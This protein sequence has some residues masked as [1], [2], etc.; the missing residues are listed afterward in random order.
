MSRTADSLAAWILL[1]LALYA[2]GLGVGLLVERLSGFRLPNALLPAVGAL[3][4][5]VLVMIPYRLGLSAVVATPLLVVAAG[6]GVWLARRELRAR[7]NPGAAGFAALGIYLLYMAP[8]ILSG[9]WTWTGYNF[10]N[11]TAVQMLLADHL[12]LDGL[13]KPPGSTTTELSIRTY[14]D[15]AYPTGSHALLGTLAPL[16]PGPLAALYQPYIAALAGLTAMALTRLASRAGLTALFAGLAAFAAVAANLTYNYGLHGSVKEIAMLCSL[17]VSVAVAREMLGSPQ[18]VRGAAVF[19]VTMGAG[20]LIFSSAALP[21]VA[22]LGLLV[23][24]LAVLPRE[25]PLRSPRRLGI[26]LGLAVPVLLIASLPALTSIFRFTDVASDAFADEGARMY[27]LAHLLR[28]L[29][30]LQS[31][32]VWL[33]NDYRVPSETHEVLTDVLLWVMMGAAVIGVVALVRR[34][35]PGVLLFSGTALGVYLIMQPRLSPYTDAKL[36]AVLSP[37]IV[38]TAAVGLALIARIRWWTA[39]PAGLCAAALLG[40]I[41]W[42]DAE[43]YH[44]TQI[45]PVEKMLAMEDVAERYSDSDD[46]LLVHESEEFAKYVMRDAPINDSFDAITVSHVRLREGQDFFGRYYDIDAVDL[47][48]LQEWELLVL[49]KSAVASRPPANWQLDYENEYYTVW[50][51]SDEPEVKEHVPFGSTTR[52]GE[53]PRCRTL[54]KLAEDAPPGWDLL[55]GALP[56][57]AYFDIEAA[58]R[59]PGWPPTLEDAVITTTPGEA[60]QRVDFDGGTYEAWVQGSFGRSIHVYIDGED[61]GAVKGVQRP[62]HW[63]RLGIVE[64]PGGTHTIR[65]QRPGGDLRPGDGYRGVLGPVAFRSTSPEELVRVPR[66]DARSLCGRP[67]DWVEVVR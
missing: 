58:R 24:V 26:A 15:T 12:R 1:P 57:I 67:L 55:A 32:G 17:A 28:P 5:I 50:R 4:S 48:Y 56:E 23:L 33:W 37:A 49:R 39:V 20:I 44:G 31:A 6:A 10:V 14:L 3:A 59:S 38:L 53:V 8:V 66:N 9:G 27:D 29:P 52:A 34:R 25:S 40:G 18:I 46:L 47:K 7:V 65:V 45:A 36:M 19:G 35:E 16:V 21:Y 30:F 43:T 64:V 62:G 60:T 11:D 42:S 41:L 54:L 61:K 13:T 22:L 51:R 2:L 63:H